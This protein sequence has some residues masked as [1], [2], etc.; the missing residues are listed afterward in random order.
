MGEIIAVSISMSIGE[1][2]KNNNYELQ[3]YQVSVL[4][5]RQLEFVTRFLDE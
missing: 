3:G 5:L 2:P 4:L 1:I